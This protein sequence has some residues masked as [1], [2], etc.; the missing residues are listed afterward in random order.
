[1]I[2]VFSIITTSIVSLFI[3][4]TIKKIEIG[5]IFVGVFGTS[6]IVMMWVGVGLSATET[7]KLEKLENVD[8]FKSEYV[9]YIEKDGENIKEFHT[10]KAYDEINDSTQIWIEKEYNMYG[11]MTDYKIFYKNIKN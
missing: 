2:T 3:F 5:Q 11:G 8:I 7:T 6:G 1:M 10:K 4:F 9:V